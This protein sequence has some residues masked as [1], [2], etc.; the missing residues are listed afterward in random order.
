MI[1]IL[2]NPFRLFALLLLL[3]L[4]FFGRTADA[5]VR[6]S[7]DVAVPR[8]LDESAAA[9]WGERLG[10]DEQ[11]V[12]AVA[13]QLRLFLEERG[14]DLRAAL[15]PATDRAGALTSASLYADPAA[16]EQFED[17]VRI[18]HRAVATLASREDEFFRRLSDVPDLLP[19]EAI[20]ASRNLRRLDRV[21]AFRCSMRRADLDLRSIVAQLRRDQPLV[22]TDEAAWTAAWPSY[23]Q[24]LASLH[25]R[26]VRDKLESIGKDAA[27]YHRFGGDMQALAEERM[28]RARSAMGVE[29]A[30]LGA[31]DR[32]LAAFC[33]ALDA[34]SCRRLREA[35]EIFLYPEVFPDPL[36]LDVLLDSIA[37]VDGVDA[38]ARLRAR[39]SIESEI[40]IL[41]SKES[42]VKRQLIER[43]EFEA[44]SMVSHDMRQAVTEAVVRL[45]AA[46]ADA[47]RRALEAVAFLRESAVADQVKALQATLDRIEQLVPGTSASPAR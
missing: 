13:A 21:A 43:D 17:L 15:A 10:W 8:P 47:A 29:R 45:R 31:N 42:E 32:W 34:A 39:A 41:R 14:P 9:S 18:R 37:V 16:V 11:T 24:E 1:R 25:D 28:A 26:R 4:P 46:R 5:Q 20:D 40:A 23:D 27:A 38:E 36:A 2:S 6:V 22:V 19:A 30:I 44:Q 35:V 7:I 3:L 33:G 12:L